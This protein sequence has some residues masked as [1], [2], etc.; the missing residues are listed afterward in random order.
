[1]MTSA[2]ATIIQAT[3][4]LLATGVEAAAEAASAAEAP[5]PAAIGAAAA[6][7][8]AASEAAWAN[9]LSPKASANRLRTKAMRSLF[10]ACC[11]VPASEG[12]LAGLAGADANDLLQRRDEDLA[13]A[14]LAGTGRGLDRLD[15]PVDDRIVD[16]GLDLHLGQEIDHVFGAAVELRMPLLPAEPLDL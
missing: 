11:S 7:A 6:A 8:E 9:A 4:P 2:V 10:M 5:E 13:V 1:M 14:D 15:D 12:V 16:R 3:S